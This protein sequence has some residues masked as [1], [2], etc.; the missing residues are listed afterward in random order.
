[1]WRMA[2]PFNTRT[3]SSDG[4]DPVLAAA[5]T[6]AERTCHDAVVDYRSGLL[7]DTEFERAVV[8][9]G[10]VI[11]ADT[12]WLLDVAGGRWWRYQG[13]APTAAHGPSEP[14]DH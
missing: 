14:G 3:N 5:L 11:T 1:M 7:N 9:A 6:N 4:L 2:V 10:L 12:V 8:R 13:D